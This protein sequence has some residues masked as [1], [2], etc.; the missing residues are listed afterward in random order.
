M[1]QQSTDDDGSVRLALGPDATLARAAEIH[2][3]LAA[4]LTTGRDLRLYLSGV[5]RAD[6]SLLQLLCS[7]HR[8]AAGQGR[9]VRL[10]EPFSPAVAAAVGA[11]GLW[12]ARGCAAGCLW[13]APEG[14][15]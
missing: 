4:A 1:S 15:R 3:A 13:A 6:V 11:A 8:T 10:A 9:Q 2:R 5:E 7:A 12:R 14:T